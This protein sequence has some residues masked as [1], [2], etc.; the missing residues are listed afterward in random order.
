M[1]IALARMR[2]RRWALAALR[3]SATSAAFDA[4]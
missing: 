3:V 4:A 2:S 1:A